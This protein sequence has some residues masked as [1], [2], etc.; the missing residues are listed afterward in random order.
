MTLAII[1]IITASNTI[2]IAIII[3]FFSTITSPTAIVTAQQ[4]IQQQTETLVTILV[5]TIQ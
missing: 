3:T 4:R 1:V 5:I 2:T